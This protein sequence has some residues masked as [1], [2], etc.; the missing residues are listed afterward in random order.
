VEN[1]CKLCLDIIKEF[2]C[3]FGKSRIG[4]ILSPNGQTNDINDEDPMGL[5]SYLFKKLNELGIAFIEV[6]ELLESR[7]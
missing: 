6:K 3:V 7:I 4:I 5:F 2:I 1:R